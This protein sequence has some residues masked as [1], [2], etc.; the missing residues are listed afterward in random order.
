MA[1]EATREGP[2]AIEVRGLELGYGGRPVLREVDFDVRPGSIF[3]IM[4]PSGCGKST[5]LK[6]MIGLIEPAA[7]EVLHWGEPFTRAAPEQRARMLRRCGVVYQK[8]ALWSSMTLSENIELVLEEYTSLSPAERR[9]MARLKLALVGLRGAEDD[10]PSQ[11]SG[12][13]QKRAALARALALDPPCSCST[14][15][16]RASTRSTRSSWTSWWS[17]C[18][19]AWA[20]RSSS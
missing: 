11:V 16:V 19:R 7:G 4:G 10:L 13:M 18:A 3:V 17:S 6:S 1:A 9:E 15:P 14:S 2:A 8:S 20:R 5:L 12:G